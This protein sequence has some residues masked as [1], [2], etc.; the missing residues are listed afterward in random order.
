MTVE[1]DTPER[2]AGR[3]G[4]G[5]AVKVS[6]DALPGKSFDGKIVAADNRIYPGVA[7][8]EAQG[9]GAE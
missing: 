8:I 9:L 1:F 7:D 5:D 3:V 6:A 4:V 2:F